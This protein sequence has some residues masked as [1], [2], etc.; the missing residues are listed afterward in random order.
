[1]VVE[2]RLRL[3]VGVE[4]KATCIKCTCVFVFIYL[5]VSSFDVLFFP[6]YFML[7]ILDLLLLANP[8]DIFISVLVVSK[9]KKN[10]EALRIPEL[11]R[12]RSYRRHCVK[13]SID[14]GPSR[15]CL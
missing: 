15:S 8:L 2:K 6:Y 10:G 3:L 5:T 7:V 12:G 11:S 14:S 1:M 4:G 13:V 9:E